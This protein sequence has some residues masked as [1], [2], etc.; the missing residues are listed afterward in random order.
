MLQAV[1]GDERMYSH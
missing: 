1:Y